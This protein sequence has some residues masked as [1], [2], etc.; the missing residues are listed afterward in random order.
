MS[1]PSPDRAH[2][3]LE[4]LV[5]DRARLASLTATPWWSPVLLGLVAGLWVAS[6]AV[7]DRTTGYVLAL[8]G[9]ALVVFLVRTRT[10]IRVSAVGPRAAG[11]AVLW[12][13]VTLLLYSASLALVSLGRSAWV[14]APAI[15]AGVV[16]WAVVRVADRWAREGLRS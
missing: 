16:T 10:G 9:A 3:L 14:P 4:Q 6:P 12:L 5:D 7:G 11:L 1:F 2:D 8:L 15:V 13:L